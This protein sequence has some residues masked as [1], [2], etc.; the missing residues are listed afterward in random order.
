MLGGVRF[1]SDSEDRELG[2]IE[3][4]FYG[5]SYFMIFATKPWD[6]DMLEPFFQSVYRR[7]EKVVKI[8]KEH[9]NVTPSNYFTK[10]IK[11]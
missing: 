7:Q 10:T 9:A 5:K 6:F 4:S 8:T 11:L 1:C 2:F 3:P